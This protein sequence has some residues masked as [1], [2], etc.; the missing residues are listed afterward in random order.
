MQITGQLAENIVWILKIAEPILGYIT[1][2]EEGQSGG[3]LCIADPSTGAPLLTW[4]FGTLTPEECVEYLEFAME[5]AK[6]LAEHPLHFAS[7]ESRDM[8]TTPKRYSGAVRGAEFILSF[9]G[10]KEEQDEAAMFLLE[11]R[12]SGG[13]LPHRLLDRIQ[14]NLYFAE[15]E[16]GVRF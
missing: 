16:C 13:P 15:L 2:H 9:S 1:E 4:A 8:N 12:I 7:S 3:V 5:K 11:S 10:F 14:E 6:R